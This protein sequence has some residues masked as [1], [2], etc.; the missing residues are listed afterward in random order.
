MPLLTDGR[1]PDTAVYVI[2]IIWKRLSGF[3]LG[4]RFIVVGRCGAE[5]NG[6]LKVG[7]ASYRWDEDHQRYLETAFET[8]FGGNWTR[9]DDDC[10]TAQ[11]KVFVGAGC[12]LPKDCVAR[13]WILEGDGCDSPYVPDVFFLSLIL[14]LG[15]FDLAMLCRIFR[16][17]G[18]LPS[19]VSDVT[20]KLSV[21]CC[22]YYHS[23]KN[24]HIGI[25]I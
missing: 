3:R 7:N 21:R 9:L 2:I 16:A 19:W 5:V 8:A 17:T 13:Q 14:F 12:L 11:N 22:V 18:Y 24:I 4:Q 23:C 20:G 15:T 10:Y 25:K 1:T 6:T